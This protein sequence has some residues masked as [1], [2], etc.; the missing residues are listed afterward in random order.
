MTLLPI[1]LYGDAILKK[2][3]K[4]VHKVDDKLMTLIKNMFDTMHNANGMG[5][6]ANQ[7]GSDKSVFIVD[8]SSVKGHEKEKPRVFLNPVI[9]EESEEKIPF[10]E[11]CLSIPELR[12]EVVRPKGIKLIY[13]DLDLKERELTDDELLARVIQHEYDHLNGVFFVERI[14]TDE[15]KKL[16]KSL[17]KIQ[18]RKIDI[19]YPVAPKAK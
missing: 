2:K 8:I 18:D 17:K 16:K 10:E 6:A 13:Q 9:V 1:T 3:A 15:L 7:V 5:L 12:A 4:K 19:D 14:E 11:G